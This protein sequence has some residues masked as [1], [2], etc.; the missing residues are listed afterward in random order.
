[1]PDI[2][3]T[4]NKNSLKAVASHRDPPQHR[5]PDDAWLSPPVHCPPPGDDV[6]LWR[7]RLDQ[8]PWRVQQMARTLSADERA[9]ADRYRFEIDRNR[10]IIARAMLRVILSRYLDIEPDQVQLCYGPHGKP[11]LRED[12]NQALIRFSVAHSHQMA[13]YALAC[14]REVGIDL[15]FT[16]P[17]GRIEQTAAEFMS[18]CELA[19]LSKLPAEQK[20][21][22]FYLCWTRK[23]AY[24]KARGLGLGQPLEQ[25]DVSIAPG[26]PA[27]LLGVEGNPNERLRWSLYSFTPASGYLAALAVE[28]HGWDTA[29]WDLA[30]LYAL[31][32]PGSMGRWN[33][34]AMS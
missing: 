9:R 5:K 4:I 3:T 29:R 11:Y 32:R 18:R 10:F 16:R 2:G 30:P 33:E 24:V 26:K 7:G 27:R 1:M 25:L 21:E 12:M 13:V 17:V 20:Q 6:H 34:T 23:E 14:A 22:A 8:P 15:E 31:C 28:G 19:L